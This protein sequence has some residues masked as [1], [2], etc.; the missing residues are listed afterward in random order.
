MWQ[1]NSKFIRSG[2][3]RKPRLPD[4]LLYELKT[5]L[6]YNYKGK[7]VIENVIPYYKPLIKPT[8][9]IGRHLFWANFSIDKFEIEQPEN[10]IMLGTVKGSEYLKK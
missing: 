3:N 7:Y 9:K 8:I 5:W 6:D 4:F 1:A 2:R 10:F